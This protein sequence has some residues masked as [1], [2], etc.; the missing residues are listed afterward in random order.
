FDGHM[1][2]LVDVLLLVRHFQSLLGEALA[3]ADVAGDEHGRQEVHLDR[4]LAVSLA[5]LAA[6]AFDVEGESARLPAA[7]TGLIG[8]GEHVA[9]MSESAGIGGG[10]RARSTSDRRLVDQDRTAEVLGAVDG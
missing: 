5:G 3:V 8:G 2:N 6:T 4:Y 10:V 9:D 1:E 7:S